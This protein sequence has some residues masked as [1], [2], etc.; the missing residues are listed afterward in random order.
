[1]DTSLF[2]DDIAEAAREDDGHHQPSHL[3]HTFPVEVKAFYMKKDPTD[4]RGRGVDCLMPG[5]GDS[6]WKHEDGRLRRADGTY[7]REGIDP[8]PYYWY[9]DQRK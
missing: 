3:P 9:T 2:G 4:L 6:W 7:K 1:M 8:V 5:V